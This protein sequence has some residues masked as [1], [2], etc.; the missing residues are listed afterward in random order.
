LAIGPVAQFPNCANLAG[1]SVWPA[2][3]T[4]HWMSYVKESYCCLGRGFY[5]IFHGAERVMIK[6]Q[7]LTGKLR[8]RIWQAS[9]HLRIVWNR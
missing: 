5:S 1:D 9:A 8:A 2:I 7:Q 4:T 3:C 6:R